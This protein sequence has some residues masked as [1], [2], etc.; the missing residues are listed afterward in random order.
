MALHTVK[1]SRPP[2]RRTRRISRSVS[3]TIGEE[4]HALLTQDYIEGT[5]FEW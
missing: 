4:L 5:A 1:A 3:D 2:R